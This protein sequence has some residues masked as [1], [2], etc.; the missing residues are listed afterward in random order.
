[1]FLVILLVYTTYVSLTVLSF[2]TFWKASAHFM[3]AS[4]LSALKKIDSVPGC[5]MQSCVLSSVSCQNKKQFHYCYSY[6]RI[7]HKG[8]SHV[9]AWKWDTFFSKYILIKN[10][11]MIESLRHDIQYFMFLI[12]IECKLSYFHPLLC[13]SVF[14]HLQVATDF[15]LLV[16][17]FYLCKT[18]TRS[19]AQLCICTQYKHM[20]ILNTCKLG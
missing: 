1:M 4:S 15:T 19:A 8:I 6:D 2:V 17:C 13:P 5:V 3:A 10:H 20:Q 9:I 18:K 11:H 12:Y 7:Y 14:L 16:L